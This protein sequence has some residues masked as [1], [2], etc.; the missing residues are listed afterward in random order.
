VT[1]RTKEDAMA[2]RKWLTTGLLAGS[3]GLGA[4]VG[5]A[6]FAPGLG[7]AQSDEGTD[8]ETTSD[9]MGGWCFGDGEGPV[10][11]AAE[12]IGIPTGDLLYAMRDG[13]TIAE[14][15][16]AEGVNEQAVIDAVVA[17]MQDKL[18]A[19]VADGFISQEL[20]D[21]LAG[22]LEARAT[23][24]V[25][26]ELPFFHGGPMHGGHGPWGGGPWSDDADEDTATS[27]VGLF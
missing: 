15:A 6:V 14:V 18:D 4:L 16:Q 24:I 22:D 1:E 19:A 2:K 21:E 23:D 5:A 8:T 9:V 7:L 10:A 26:G 3:I 25:N 12:A 17:S 11:A 27:N 20:A 13:S